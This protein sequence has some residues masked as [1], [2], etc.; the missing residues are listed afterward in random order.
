MV[1]SL[2]QVLDEA[3]SKIGDEAGEVFDNTKLQPYFAQ[4]YR[5]LWRTMATL[6]N[7]RVHREAFFVLPAHTAFLDPATA[8]LTDFGDPDLLEERGNFVV[9]SITGAVADPSGV[10]VIVTIAGHGDAT[11]NIVTC[12][13]VQGMA[14]TDGDWGITVLDPD[15][16]VLNGAVPVGTY[17]SG[18]TV[19][20][21]GEDFTE[22]VDADLTH[23]TFPAGESSTLGNYRWMGD[24]FHFPPCSQDRQLRIT[25]WAS[26]TAPSLST[27]SIGIDDA[28]DFLATY[29]AGLAISARSPMG[30]VRGKELI[31][32]A[33]GP[34][35]I[36][37]GS[38]GLLWEL[39]NGAV[40]SMQRIDPC[41]RRRRP[42]REPR[43]ILP[44]IF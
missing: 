35:T 44:Q 20:K 5:G 17:S 15:T 34:K 8:G 32:E 33:I 1:P 27:V 24:K 9:Q 16:F 7:P 6:S 25:Y 14:G 10:G 19:V 13:G 22:V 21:S 37:D 40:K 18:G 11:G 36:A 41:Q 3:R 28:L 39:L 12:N 42:F 23:H 43:S 2:Q 31:N 26:G 30:S 4:A 29:T 38:G